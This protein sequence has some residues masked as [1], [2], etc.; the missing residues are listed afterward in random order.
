VQADVSGQGSESEIDSEVSSGHDTTA[1]SPK[2][3]QSECDEACAHA[4]QLFL[5]QVYAEAVAAEPPKA[6]METSRRWPGVMQ[7]W[8]KGRSKSHAYQIARLG[9]RNATYAAC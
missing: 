8:S 1:T 9:G 5:A 4:G 3:T 7:R 2:A 6:Q